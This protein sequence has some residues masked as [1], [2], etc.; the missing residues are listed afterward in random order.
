MQSVARGFD[1]YEASTSQ[2]NGLRYFF[3]TGFVQYSM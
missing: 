3:T 2:S 1:L